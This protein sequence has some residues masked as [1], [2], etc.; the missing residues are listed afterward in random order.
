MILISHTFY[1]LPA[2]PSPLGLSWWLYL[3]FTPHLDRFVLSNIKR[4]RSRIQNS[5]GFLAGDRGQRGEELEV[6]GPKKLTKPLLSFLSSPSWGKEKTIYFHYLLHLASLTQLTVSV[7]LIALLS[8]AMRKN[9]TLMYCLKQNLFPAD[10]KEIEKSWK[11]V[12]SFHSEV[13]SSLAPQ[14]STVLMFFKCLPRYLF[15]F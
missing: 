15:R 13:L 11:K 4:A 10:M 14:V 8:N 1:S 3:A 9:Q 12:M 6:S 2:S 7:L 5:S